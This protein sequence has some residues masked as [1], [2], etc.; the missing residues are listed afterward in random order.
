MIEVASD[1]GGGARVRLNELRRALAG[2]QDPV[3][4]G[5]LRVRLADALVATGDLSAAAAELKQAAADAPASVG[6][7]F[8]A[9]ALAARLPPAESKALLAAVARGSAAGG[10]TRPSPSRPRATLPAPVAAKARPAVAPTLPTPAAFFVPADEPQRGETDPIDQALAAVAARKPARARRLGEEVARSGLLPAERLARLHKLVDVLDRSGARRQALLLV[11]TLA[12]VSPPPEPL[13]DEPARSAAL[14]VGALSDLVKRAL[15]SGDL[16]LALRWGTDAGRP[17]ARVSQAD[18]HSFGDSED[19]FHERFLTAQAAASTADD[20]VAIDAAIDALAP[21]V[22][23]DQGG[24]AALAL[25]LGLADRLGGGRARRIDLY[26]IA[27]ESEPHREG[28]ERIAR[29]WLQTL[30]QD[31]APPQTKAAEAINFLAALERAI[32]DMPAEQT[33]SLRKARADLLRQLGRDAELARALES[34]AEIAIGPELVALLREQAERLD[35]IGEA[36]RALE[37]RLGALQDDPG[38]LNLLAPAR[39]RLEALGQQERSLELAIAALPHITDRVARAAHL[40]DVAALAETTA[41]DRPRAAAAWLE[42]LGLVPDDRAALESAERLLRLLGDNQRL[43]ELLAW[44]VARTAD[45]GAR[46]AVLWR[47]AE[48]RRGEGKRAAALSLYREIIEMQGVGKDAPQEGLSWRRRDDALTVETAR[49]MAASDPRARAAAL[50]DRALVLLEAG[51]LDDAERD[52]GRAFDLDPDGAEILLALEKLHDRRGDF[53]GLRQ[54]L[55]VKV[56]RATG[57]AAARIWCGVGRA[58]ERLGELGAAQNAYAQGCA[59]DPSDRAPLGALRRLADERRDFAEVARLLEK[60]VELVKAPAERVALL[61]EL[62]GLFVEKLGRAERAVEVLDAALAFQ[63]SNA[64]ALETMYGA[65]LGAGVWEKAA[66]A[67]E[68]LLAAHGGIADAAERYYRVGLA[69]E[70]EG[71]MDRALGFY[72]RSYGRN[73]SFRPTLERLSEIC[74][75][76]QQWDNAWKATEHLIERHGAAIE[77][78]ARA[79]LAVRSAL[80]D[81]HIAQRIAAVARLA[82]VPGIPSS[83]AGLRDVAESWASMRFDPQLLAGVD[84]ER[85]GRV[86]SRLKEGLALPDPATPSAARRTA[87]EVL[88]A[89]AFLDRRWADAVESLDVFGV[90]ETFDAGRRCLYQVAAGDILIHQQGDVVGAAL[91]YER[92]RALNPAEPRLARIG[93]VQIASEI[94]EENTPV[95]PILKG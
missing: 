14:P 10:G 78:A 46:L 43:G 60:E 71:K 47:L 42:V 62:G 91:R 57:A 66:Q 68:A 2:A 75:D 7:L 4:R 11:R 24:R 74:F 72:S 52:L 37:V 85:R 13:L 5:R 61:V 18:A 33:L 59:A 40:R 20:D 9:R 34:D 31:T 87:R 22:S 69:A 88:A 77:P 44:S 95:S 12:E 67:L 19:G 49:A 17:L 55:Q 58:S 15:E 81:L 28:R 38:N 89:F 76:R 23:G 8:G 73:S 35:R 39:R 6:L 26:R 32:A 16:D 50:T 41:E 63:P 51:R 92:A 90:D 83:G 70:A 21:L 84:D 36:D 53:R 93:V 1:T 86:L 94:E 56:A 64:G 48:Y 3:E 30:E 29:L 80:A 65:A 25:A 82:R 54:R 27:F 79:E 45:P